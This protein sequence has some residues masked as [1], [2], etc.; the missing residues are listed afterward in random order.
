MYMTKPHLV[1]HTHVAC[2][3]HPLQHLQASSAPFATRCRQRALVAAAREAM[4][5]TDRDRLP[6]PGTV[7]LQGYRRRAVTTS[8]QLLS[9]AGPCCAHRPSQHRNIS[10]SRGWGSCG[11]LNSDRSPAN[12]REP[13]VPPS[14]QPHPSISDRR[15]SRTCS[16]MWPTTRK[17]SA[18]SACSGGASGAARPPAC[19][20]AAAAGRPAGRLPAG[21]QPQTERRSALQPGATGGRVVPGLGGTWDAGSGR[22][23]GWVGDLPGRD[24][25][26]ECGPHACRKPGQAPWACLSCVPAALH[27]LTLEPHADRQVGEVEAQHQQRQRHRARRVGQHRQEQV[28]GNGE[29]AP[30]VELRFKAW[31]GWRGAESGPPCL[32]AWAQRAGWRLGSASRRVAAQPHTG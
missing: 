23:G 17:R 13:C 15:R 2:V 19:P 7:M 20:P 25:W 29:V 32:Q 18:L 28:A 24:S 22:N 16:R 3:M 27:P 6:M 10:G 12:D 4:R 9:A 30:R 14:R 11:Q 8:C 31:A 26:H 21:R 1:G 5:E